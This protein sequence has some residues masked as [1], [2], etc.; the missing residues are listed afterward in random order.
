MHTASNNNDGAGDYDQQYEGKYASKYESEQDA[1]S[2]STSAFCECLQ[3]QQESTASY[4]ETQS[5]FIKCMEKANKVDQDRWENVAK[6]YENK[7]IPKRVQKMMTTTEEPEFETSDFDPFYS[8]EIG[9]DAFYGVNEDP[10]NDQAVGQSA[11]DNVA[12]YV[13]FIGA[14]VLL[15]VCLWFARHTFKKWKMREYSSVFSESEAAASYND[16]DWDDMYGDD[17]HYANKE[18]PN[19]KKKKGKF[20]E[21]NQ[22]SA[23]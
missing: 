14:S 23:V 17:L 12:L 6:K 18:E 4:P 11:D 1:Y 5:A 16:S 20:S 19:N 10:F 13:T 15:F 9:E 2:G 22:Y 21:W 3:A 8:T 7:Y